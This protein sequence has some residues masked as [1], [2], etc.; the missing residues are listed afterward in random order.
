MP[1]LDPWA[2][3][4]GSPR[5]GVGELLCEGSRS[6]DQISMAEQQ[7]PP[8]LSHHQL[9]AIRKE[10]R[11]RAFSDLIRTRRR[12]AS[13]LSVSVAHQGALRHSMRGRR[14]PCSTD[15]DLLG[16][17]P[18]RPHY[19]RPTPRLQRPEALPAAS[20]LHSGG[21]SVAAW[22]GSGAQAH[23]SSGQRGLRWK[24]V[25]LPMARGLMGAAAAG[26]AHGQ[27]A[28]ILPLPRKR[29][30]RPQSHGP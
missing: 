25:S 3:V 2:D 8:S 26:R 7:S 18:S 16:A 13:R 9:I 6:H 17:S 27:Y 22:P 10:R 15:L 12:M 1:C 24:S 5:D 21:E 4:S 14:M 20:A 23:S 19:S 28:V 30:V 11:R 29:L